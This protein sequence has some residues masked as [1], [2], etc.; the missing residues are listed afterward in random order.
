MEYIDKYEPKKEK[1]DKYAPEKDKDKPENQE[2][3]II[4]DDT[5]AIIE[6]IYELVGVIIRK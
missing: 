6:A 2:K 4:S 1:I 3:T 5:Y